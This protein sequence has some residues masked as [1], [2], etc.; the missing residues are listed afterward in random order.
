[1]F[2]RVLRLIRTTGRNLLVLWYA[3]R[4]PATP[5][6]LKVAALLLV[7]YAFSPLDLLP[8]WLAVLGWIDDVSLLA[9][10][11]PAILRRLPPHVLNEAESSASGFRLRTR[12]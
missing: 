5:R 8:D 10:G 4:H 11:I 6:S 12:T 3:C 1:M 2:L 9:I 7:A